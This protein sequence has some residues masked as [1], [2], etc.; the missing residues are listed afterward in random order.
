MD[1]NERIDQDDFSSYD[2]ILDFDMTAG[3]VE[4]PTKYLDESE[5]FFYRSIDEY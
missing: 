4:K 5:D 1:I 3:E 2:E